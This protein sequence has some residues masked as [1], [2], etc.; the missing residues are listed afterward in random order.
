DKRSE[1]SNTFCRY[2]GVRKRFLEALMEFLSR[3]KMTPA[4]KRDHNCRIRDFP[5][6]KTNKWGLRKLW[7]SESHRGKSASGTGRSACAG[8]GKAGRRG[9][10]L[11]GRKIWLP[12][13]S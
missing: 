6:I 13:M 7:L 12:Q 8:R 11:N 4:G 5:R 9:F 1:L 3:R 10:I 2:I